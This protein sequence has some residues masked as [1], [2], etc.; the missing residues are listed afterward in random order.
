MKLSTKA[1]VEIAIFGALGFALDIFQ[2]GIT[3]GLFPN[4]GSIGIAILPILIITFRRGIKA[5][6]LS[7]LILSFLQLLGGLYLSANNWYMMIL[8]LILDYILAY[9]LIAVA[10]IFYKPFHNANTNKQKVTFLI[11]ATIIGGLSKLLCHYLAGVIFWQSSCPDGYP[12]GPYIYSLVYN[13]SYMIPNIILNGLLLVIIS[14]K[15]PQIFKDFDG[16]KDNA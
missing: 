1:V 15:L 9:P 2:G 10:G 8:Q 3:R 13:G 14:L 4:G 12:G 16:G 11:I 6:L 7:G 5:G